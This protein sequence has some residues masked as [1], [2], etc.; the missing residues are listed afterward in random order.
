MRG[1]CES[2]V[3]VW[4]PSAALLLQLRPARSEA[5]AGG[6]GE[7]GKAGGGEGQMVGSWCW[8][9]GSCGREVISA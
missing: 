1:G 7:R 6:E 9:E 3:S 8:R 2:V 4:P 5:V